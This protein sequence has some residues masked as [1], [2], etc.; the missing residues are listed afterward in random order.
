MIAM[1]SYGRIGG[2]VQRGNI[3]Y[4]AEEL[5]PKTGE[6]EGVLGTG[7]VLGLGPKTRAGQPLLQLRSSEITQGFSGAPIWDEV[8]HRVI[9]MVVI[10]ATPD[11]SGK[12]GETAFATPPETLQ[13]ICLDLIVSDVCPYRNLGAF[14]EAD[15][16]F[17]FG[18]QRVID[19][20]VNSLRNEPRFLALL[21]PS[22]SGKS[23]VVQAGLIPQL[24]QGA[25]PGSDRWEIIVTRPTD[26]SFRQRV[27]TL[28]QKV[29]VRRVLVIDQF[30]ELFVSSS[31]T[32]HQSLLARLTEFLD[33]VSSLTIVLTMRDDFYSSLVRYEAFSRRLRS[34]LLNIPASL[35]YQE[36]LD[37]IEKPA[38]LVG[39][40]FE[41]GLAETIAKDTLE[42]VPHTIGRKKV[43]S[44]TVLP[45]LEF[46][47]TQLWERRS[48]GTLTYNAY[49]SIGEVTG[50]LAQWADQ[51]FYSL[52]EQQRIIA[53]RI[54][55]NLVHLGSESQGLPNS[56]R[57]RFLTSLLRKDDERETVQYIIRRLANAR[58]LVT[59]RD[60]RNNEETV[61]II[62]E[63]LLC[64]WGQLTEWIRED[65][66]FLLW[67]QKFEQRFQEWRE[68]QAID[69]TQRD[70]DKLLRGRDL[71]EAEE[72]LKDRVEDLN[73]EE[74]GF[75][76]LSREQRTQ[77]EKHLKSLLE[78]SEHRR[79]IALARELAAQAEL[80]HNQHAYLL[81]RSVLLAVEAMKRSPSLEA[82]QALRHGLS[83]LPQR[84]VSR[85][86]LQ[87]TL[88]VAAFSPNSNYVAAASQNGTV[89]VWETTSWRLIAHLTHEGPMRDVAFS[90]NEQY[91][92]TASWDGAAK[93]WETTSWHLLTTL[94]HKRAVLAAAFSPNGRHLITASSDHTAK[95][96]E[97]TSWHQLAN[98]TH[99]RAV[100]NV[101]FSPNGHHVV[102]ASHDHTARVWEV[103][104]GREMARL[105][106]DGAVNAA[107]FSPDGNY[108]ATASE[109]H[110]ARI[111]ET[112][113]TLEIA[114]L[115]HDDTVY[116]VAFS[117]DG[118]YLA[119]A[120]DDSTAI[121]W[122]V[123]SARQR[124]R[125]VH[126]GSIHNVTFSPDGRYLA[127]ASGDGSA[128]MWEITSGRQLIRFPQRNGVHDVAFNREGNYLVTTGDGI[129]NVWKT[130]SNR[131]RTRFV[132]EASVEAV[133]FSPDGHYV[134]TA[135]RDNT[136]RIW[137]TTNGHQLTCLTHKDA[138]W[139]VS[140]SP[141]GHYL[142]T[143]SWDHTA[144]IWDVSSGNQLAQFTHEDKVRA[145]A[146]SPDGHYLATASWD[147]TARIWDVHSKRQLKS[148]IHTKGVWKVIFS[149]D[150]HYIATASDD[151]TAGLWETSSGRQHA[152]LTHKKKVRDVTFSSD[153]R[154]LATAS[155]DGVV[156][157]WEVSNGRLHT[158]LTHNSTVNAI[159][160]N[161]DGCFLATASWDRSARVWEVDSGCEVASFTHENGVESVTFSPD[162]RFLATASW[163]H[164][165][166]V[167]E[168]SSNRQI[169][170]LTH[171]SGVT[172]ITF[173]PNG[174]YVATASGDGT[175]GVWLWQPEELIGEAESRLTRN[176]TQ[177]EWKQYMGDEP[178]HK[179][180]PD[181]P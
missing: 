148:L 45:L 132:H 26:R 42:T 41:Q 63:A 104:S 105:R 82:D 129:A 111:W 95:V 54:F 146:F 154:Y 48:D 31:E 4:T 181:L 36:V 99:K 91:L 128:G 37:I 90:P 178:Y 112:L 14:A 20:M 34:A 92:V 58:L 139:A 151:H 169:A 35:T 103:I 120:S 162:G 28:D 50:G 106:H 38:Q 18:R 3:V 25:I 49:K 93:V 127:T 165:A 87:G 175:A 57:R 80:T 101:A 62:H 33:K 122:D 84:L 152:R 29:A 7:E 81:E 166:G 136:A 73:S 16:R 100:L 1:P 108:V 114:C 143:A 96:W 68:T 56:S 174:K 145:V 137:E 157:V 8:R 17:F 59:S 117:P 124:A 32:E 74:Q 47:L 21:G 130:I 24:R 22:G 53:R 179:T 135:S 15:A 86:A 159:S 30:E 46:A 180:C 2:S 9:G 75:I 170:R 107:A 125:L 149:P 78:E 97:T 77:E 133:I 141:N 147:C 173:S 177:E 168:I 123:E 70:A 171:E 89:G 110:T 161:P 6:V 40:H 158:R 61:E 10:V 131:Q 19:E 155:E 156:K 121:I 64:E 79:Q 113:T 163:D 116:A 85:L 44:S 160:F 66:G 98:L 39:V 119:T 102:T 5:V 164:T 176:L 27:D 109:D 60:G 140:F 72:W 142:A 69:A 94:T 76:Y 150:G 65:R 167:W 134:A 118:H 67:Y 88:W 144:A 52:D 172:G 43:A 12:L 23:S 138:V 83:L 115:I 71:S 11:A 51:E 153:G 126:Q 55:T 13:T